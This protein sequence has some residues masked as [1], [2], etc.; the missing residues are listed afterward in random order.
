LRRPEPRSGDHF[1]RSR[2]DDGGSNFAECPIPAAL[3]VVTLDLMLIHQAAVYGAARSG[4]RRMRG[5]LTEEHRA[6]NF[7]QKFGLFP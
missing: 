2:L 4:V 5:W 1:A 7:V 3:G 6:I